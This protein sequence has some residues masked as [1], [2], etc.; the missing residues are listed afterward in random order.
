MKILKRK[1]LV[2]V[3]LVLFALAVSG[4]TYAYWASEVNGTEDSVVDDN[5]TIGT[6]EAITIDVTVADTTDNS[7]LLIPSTVTPKTGETNSI[8]VSYTVTWKNDD[9]LDGVADQTVS[10]L[11]ENIAVNGVANPYN[12]ISVEADVNNPTTIGLNETV[13][14]NFVVTMDEPLNVTQYNAVAGLPITFNITFTVGEL[15]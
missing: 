6:G 1:N 2:L 11:V 14:F 13:T 4:T 5:V 9:L 10:A 8:T 15:A 3:L 7:L 12:L